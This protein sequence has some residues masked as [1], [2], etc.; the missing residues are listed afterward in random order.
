MD[1][2]CILHRRFIREQS[3]DWQY[4]RRARYPD[5]RARIQGSIRVTEMRL[6]L[7]RV[8]HPG[9]VHLL[10]TMQDARVLSAHFPSASNWVNYLERTHGRLLWTNGYPQR[11]AEWRHVGDGIGVGAPDYPDDGANPSTRQRTS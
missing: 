1:L 11:L 8:C 5:L 10:R 7:T 6:G 9:L 4:R 3:L 2:A